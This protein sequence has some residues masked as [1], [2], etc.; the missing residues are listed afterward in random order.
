MKKNLGQYF[1]NNPILKNYVYG[2]I[3][4][5]PDI[6]LEPSFGQGD[7]VDTDPKN[8]HHATIHAFE[9]DDAISPLPL[10]TEYTL[11][12]ADFLTYPI[13][14][15]YDTIIGNPPYVKTKTKNLY[16]Q[17]IEKCIDLLNENGEIIFIVP[18][19][20][21]KITSSQSILQKMISKGSF[22]HFVFPHQ[23]NLFP[24]ANIDVMIFRYQK[25][26]FTNKVYV[27]NTLQYILFHNGIITF[28]TRQVKNYSV[29]KDF[30]DVYVGM[31]SAK[32]DIFKHGH[33]GN[34]WIQTGQNK[35]EKY[36]IIHKFPTNNQEL[37]DY[38]VKHKTALQSRKIRK[39][40]ETNWFEWGALRN[41]NTIQKNIGKKCIYIHT[42]TR[43]KE[44]AFIGRVSLF[45]GNLLI[46]IPKKQISLKKVCQYL[47]SNEFKD[48]Y[49]YSGRFKIGHK[50]LSSALLNIS[51]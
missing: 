47:N 46:M 23:E 15:K 11:I 1:T 49:T 48:N 17:F 4:N 32:E 51:L 29:V 21:I 12:Y 25:D 33:Y 30:F 22:T 19:D 14:I 5:H 27:N 28:H 31:V 40:N 44:I 34:H 38:L 35:Q 39:F 18:S 13:T 37:D 3:Q 20:F 45:N 26:L 36:I 8:I 24:S 7:L 16:I 42:L 2:M 50:Q 9:I 10:N 41:F 6:I 43:K